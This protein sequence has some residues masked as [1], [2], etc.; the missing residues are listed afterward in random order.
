[1]L[2][3]LVVLVLVV[4][5][6]L[7]AVAVY[8]TYLLFMAM[9]AV[10]G[11]IYFVSFLLFANV[12]GDG[13]VGYAVASAA[14]VGSVVNYG[15]YRLITASNRRNE[16]TDRGDPV[17]VNATASPSTPAARKVHGN[18]LPWIRRRFA[19]RCPCGSGKAFIDCHG[20]TPTP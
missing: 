11:A 12:F 9:L 20:K 7:F 6:G 14:V 2:I 15:L 4:I 8:I 5:L 1:M 10:A 18:S 17:V 19:A 16:A 3:A 13:N